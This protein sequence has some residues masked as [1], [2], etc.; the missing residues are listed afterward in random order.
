M[1]KPDTNQK[2]A[3]DGAYKPQYTL[4]EP[5]VALVVQIAEGGSSK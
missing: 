3:D 5:I 1:K 2:P 4:T